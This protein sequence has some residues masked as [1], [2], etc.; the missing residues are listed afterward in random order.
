MLKREGILLTGHNLD[1]TT[2]FEGFVCVNKRDYYKVGSTWGAL[3]TYSKYLAY[4]FNWISKYGS[5]T[6]SSQGRDLPDAGINEAGLVIEEMSLANHPYP[7]VGIRPRLFQMQ[8]IQYHLDTYSTVGQVIRSASLILPDGWP[9]HFFVADKSGNCATLEYI[10]NKLVVHT[11]KTLPVT[12]LCN[13]TYEE[14]LS[15]LA[16]YKGFGGRKAIDLDD[17]SIPRFVRSAH[18]LNAY[19]PE[20]QPS[21]VDYV[22]EIL[23]NLSSNLTRRS[24][25]VDLTNEV[26]Y[27][28]TGSH[29]EIRHFSLKS[30]DFS[31]DTPVQIL[32][33]NARFSGDVT[34]KFQNYTVQANRRVAESWVK[35]AIDMHPD[36]TERDRIEAGLTDE[37]IDRYARYPSLSLAKSNLETEEN[38][39]NL[40]ELYWAAYLGESQKVRNLLENGA[41]ANVTTGIGTTPLMA[42]TQAGHMDVVRYLLDSGAEIDLADRRGNTP[43]I[44]AVVFGQPDI[45][46]DLIKTG[47]KVQLANKSNLGPLHYS[48]ANGDLDST[49]LLLAE[50]AD[51]EDKSELGWTALISAAFYGKTEVVKYLVSKGAD[52]KAVDKYGNTALLVALLLKHSDVAKELIEAGSDVLVQNNE[53]KTPWSLASAAENKKVMQLLKEAGVKPPRNILP[54]AVVITVVSVLALFAYGIVSRK[55][56]TDTSSDVVGAGHLCSGTTIVK[57]AAILLNTFQV[58]VGILF[59]AMKGLPKEPMEWVLLAIWFIIPMV[60]FMAIVL[61]GRK[62]QD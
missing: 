14:E 49:K 22:F 35:H 11:G 26:V 15:K 42:A 24:Y 7:P 54:I 53:G 25:V 33:L 34:D 10:G 12:A 36:G 32:D 2:D 46:A 55:R 58:V 18:M 43:L 60:N 62:G 8:W 17:K 41:D 27:F 1:E 57:Y 40:T 59:L 48:A 19:D 31:C 6:W 20:A 13:S 9:W 38:E 3:K 39:Y 44:A 50:G 61:L 23:E 21:A 51:M 28:R 16:S 45:A 37:H 56:R 30:F 5:I 47:A 4:S 29:P 52:L